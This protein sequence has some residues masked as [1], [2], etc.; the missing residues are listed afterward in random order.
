MTAIED[1]DFEFLGADSLSH[2]NYQQAIL[3][4]DQWTDL[5]NYLR[6]KG[7]NPKRNRGFSESNIRPIARRI[8]QGHQFAWDIDPIKTTLSP[9]QADQFIDALNKD[10]VRNSDGEPYAEG[11]KRKFRQALETYFDFREI[12]WNP[13]IKFSEDHSTFASDPF[14]LSE[15][16]QLLNASFEYQ[17]PPLYCNVSPDERDRWNT[18]LAQVLGKSK[19]SI[20]PSDWEDL[21][22]CWK[23]PSL[24]ST[25]LDCGWR[26]AMV[27]R[28]ETS[29]V[30]IGEGR[31]KIP[32]NIAVKNDSHWDADLSSRS[33]NM[34]RR[35]FEQRGN[36]T[37]YDSSDHIWLNRKGN[38]YAS[39]T[40]NDLLS[41]LIDIA[42]I[43]TQGRRLTWHSIRHS[44]G[45]YVF[46][47]KKDLEL[48]AE[49]L[50]HAT[51]E[52]ARKYAHPTSETKKDVIE[53]IQGDRAQ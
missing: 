9:N 23:I 45:M 34:L 46:D 11:S 42:D 18:H 12:D 29:L 10:T 33:E 19:Q 43:N 3:Y 21:Q 8:H 53:S 28:L 30:N 51:L 2:L 38:P 49:I 6:Q 5:L 35:W 13:D 36:R 17:S 1:L 15:R 32:P 40:L 4:R 39:N 7:K 37:K 25:S 14:T 48:V 24:I 47:Q 31:I 41:N 22:H 27:G 50:R 26:A 20:G 16:E 52:A 44:T